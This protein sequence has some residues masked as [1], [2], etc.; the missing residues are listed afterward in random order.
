[1]FTPSGVNMAA[2]LVFRKL[3]WKEMNLKFNV[4]V[5]APPLIHKRRLHSNASP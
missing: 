5:W 2:L 1:M 3:E 4:E